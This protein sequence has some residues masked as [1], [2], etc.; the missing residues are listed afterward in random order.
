MR[1]NC[2]PEVE[3]KA[4][5]GVRT[6]DDLLKVKELGVTRVGATATATMINDAIDRFGGEKPIAASSDVPET[7]VGQL[8]D[9]LQD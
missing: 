6:L 8:S 3:V 2:P 1:A 5:G 9:V 7:L 4:A